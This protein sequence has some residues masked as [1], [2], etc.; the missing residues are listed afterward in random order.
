VSVQGNVELKQKNY[1]QQNLN[2]GMKAL[3]SIQQRQQEGFVLP[4]LYFCVINTSGKFYQAN[5][6]NFCI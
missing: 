6:E 3:S 5:E 2:G 4:F 1:K